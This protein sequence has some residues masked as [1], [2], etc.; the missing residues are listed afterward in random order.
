[1]FLLQVIMLWKAE[2]R[3]VVHIKIYVYETPIFRWLSPIICK[4]RS[5]Q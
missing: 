1:M 5:M 4:I 2:F 3:D